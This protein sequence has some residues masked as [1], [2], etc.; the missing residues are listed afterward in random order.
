[1]FRGCPMGGMMHRFDPQTHR[2][3]CGRWQN[4]FKPKCAP[5]RA[6]DECQI[7]ER[8]QALD[9]TGCLGHHGYK[10]PGWGFITGD[11]MGAGYKPY[12]MTDALKLYLFAVR[13]HIVKCQDAL[14]KLPTLDEIDYH[15]TEYLGGGKKRRRTRSIKRGEP[16]CYT[17]G[18]GHPGFDHI[19]KITVA[20]LENE[21]EFAK[22]DEA[23]VC[24][25][26]LAA[27][28]KAKV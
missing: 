17:P 6:R 28:E 14:A 8:Q 25:R 23:R 16:A 15:D 24:A 10:R 12:P 22:K 2:C 5:V 21:I 19:V 20:N 3:R 1:M 11:C 18:I 27:E 4:G 7:C 9:T 26:I 13:G